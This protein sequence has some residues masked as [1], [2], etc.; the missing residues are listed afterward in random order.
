MEY[1]PINFTGEHAQEVHEAVLEANRTAERKL[2]RTEDDVKNERLF[3]SV[4]GGVKW[5]KY[6]EKIREADIDALAAVNDLK[7]GDRKVTPKKI[8]AFDNWMYDKL[9]FTR[10]AKSMPAGAANIGSTDFEKA[11]TSY[12]I[13][14]MG[15]SYE[16]LIYQSIS[17]DTK[18]A[19]A[20][21][22]T[23]PASQK[24]WAAAQPVGEF[25]GLIARMISATD[26][27]V[28]GGVVKA[29]AGTTVSALNIVDEYAKIYNGID[30]AE[31]EEGN[32]KIF[33]PLADFKILQNANL[34]QSFRDKFVVSGS[35][36]DT[37]VSFLNVP[38]EFVPTGGP[39]FSGKAGEDGDFLH[40]TDL[41]SDS[42]TFIVKEVNNYSDDLFFKMVAT[43]DTTVLNS[44]KK[45]LYL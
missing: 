25:D 21:S 42:T 30:D 45:V 17:A 26:T 14:R 44:G 13:P 7:F 8:M 16:A 32:V 20:A 15:K 2:L 39:R 3:T 6:K 27:E 9:R 36:K 12:L 29:V 19:I 34:Q 38:V 18:A 43:A 40:A 11:A 33:S 37:V 22:A 28:G 1:A 35:G 4:S 31:L 10:F 24:A 5:Q 23:V 41:L